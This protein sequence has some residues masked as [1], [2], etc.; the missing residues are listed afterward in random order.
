MASRLGY[1]IGEVVIKTSITLKQAMTK[2]FAQG[3]CRIFSVFEQVLL[4]LWTSLG[5][6][7]MRIVAGPADG[8]NML[9]ILLNNTQIGINIVHGC[10]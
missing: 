1:F 4:K 9:L 8:R 6:L 3:F 10:S 5:V 2:Y 7:K